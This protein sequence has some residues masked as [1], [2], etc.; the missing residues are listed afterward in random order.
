MPSFYRKK[1]AAVTLYVVAA[2]AG[3]PAHAQNTITTVTAGNT[4]GAIAVNPMTNRIYVANETDNYVTV[5]NGA[6]NGTTTIAAGFGDGLAVNPVTNKIYVPNEYFEN[7]TGAPSYMTVIDG[8]MNGA[9]TIAVGFGPGPDG[10]A[11]N[12]VTNQIY[13]SNFDNKVTV[14]DGATN[15][16]TTVETGTS[17]GPI[18]VNSVTNKIYVANYNSNNVT[19]IDGATN[20]TTTVPAGNGPWAI[21]V[22]TVTNQIYVANSNT[23]INQEY[24]PNTSGTVTVIDGAT[25]ATTTVPVGSDPEVIAVNSVTNKIYVPNYDSNNVTVI[26]G[27]TNATITVLVG[28]YPGAIA[29]NSVTNKIYVGNRGSNSVTV[30][31]GATNGADTITVGSNPDAIAVNPVTDMIYVANSGSANVTVINGAAVPV[32]PSFS[33]QPQSVTVNGGASV[34]FTASASSTF[35]PTYQ[36]SLNGTVLADGGGISGSLTSTLYLGGAAVNAGTYTCTATNSAGI[37]SSNG[38]T[39]TVVNTSTPGRLV[40]ISARALVGT[41]ANVLI[42]G[43]VIQGSA[44]LPVLLRSSGSALIPFGVTGVLPDPLL[45]LYSGS[46]VIDSNAGWGGNP[47]IVSTASAVGAFAWANPASKDSAILETQNPGAYTAITSGVSGDSGVALAEV[48]D[49]THSGTWNSSLPRLGNISARAFVGTGSNVLIAGFVI[50]GSTAKT[51]LIRA[52]GPAL[53]PPLEPR[54]V[55]PDPQLQLYSGSTVIDSNARWGGNVAVAAAASSVG[56]FAWSDPSSYDSAILVTLPPGAYSAIVS[57]VSGDT[58]NSLVE[59]YDV[60]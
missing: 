5:I 7:I 56:A 41:G 47:R 28:S 10:I 40:D 20:A 44:P 1:R 14:I 51:V 34:A 8:A 39:L 9:N 45:Q 29:V 33:S 36:W 58:R 27:A 50:G 43:Y 11:V 24:V 52:S 13:V 48:Y 26:D 30:I 38:A 23:V 35:I 22:N 46:T 49:T 54:E 37:A 25:N 21:A 31:D 6:T 42:A 32:S 12:P 59:V 18:A 55:L 19:V 17:P 15:G 53:S 57:G 3:L 16:T 4:P 2:I 60:P